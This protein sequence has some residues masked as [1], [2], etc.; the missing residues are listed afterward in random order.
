MTIRRPR[1]VADGTDG[2]DGRALLLVSALHRGAKRMAQWEILFVSCRDPSVQTAIEALRWDTGLDVSVIPEGGE[3][4]ALSGAQLFA[5]VAFRDVEYLP[6][7]A[8]VSHS[9]PMLVAI[10]FPDPARHGA[11]VFALQRAAHDP[12]RLAAALVARI[13]T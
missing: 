6:L 5:A 12:E 13:G 10:Q 11:A 4:R 1:L 9:V 2:M 7:G 8:I 3:G